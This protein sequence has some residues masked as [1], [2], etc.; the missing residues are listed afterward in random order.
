[1]TNE[2]FR[3][4]LLL[5]N[6][7][8]Y[9]VRYWFETKL[10]YDRFLLYASASLVLLLLVK[11]VS[12]TILPLIVLGFCIKDLLKLLKLNA[13]YLTAFLNKEANESDKLSIE[14]K[15]LDKQVGYLFLIG[16]VL[17]VCV[18]L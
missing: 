11:G 1:M 10:A 7:I 6:G 5:R 3:E 14:L 15:K 4:S 9:G 2:K 12:S 8:K 13:D 17:A 16:V 18:L